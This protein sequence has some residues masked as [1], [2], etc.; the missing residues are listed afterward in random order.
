MGTCQG[1]QFLV[2]RV[3]TAPHWARLNQLHDLRFQLLPMKG[4]FLV[5]QV[6]F[7]EF[8]YLVPGEL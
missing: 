6:H 5:V 8:H 3:L 1:R 2:S 4:E 7:M